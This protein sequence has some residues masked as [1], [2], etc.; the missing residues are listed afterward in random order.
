MSD[1]YSD[2]IARYPPIV[3]GPDQFP[4]VTGYHE[5]AAKHVSSGNREVRNRM[6]ELVGKWIHF[7]VHQGSLLHGKM[8]GKSFFLIDMEIKQIDGKKGSQE[9]Y[10]VDFQHPDTAHNAAIIAYQEDEKVNA[11]VCVPLRQWVS[12]ELFQQAFSDSFRSK[13][14]F[15]IDPGVP[16]DPRPVSRQELYEKEV[17]EYWEKIAKQEDAIPPSPPEPWEI[18]EDEKALVEWRKRQEATE[19]PK[20]ASSTPSTKRPIGASSSKSKGTRGRIR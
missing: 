12:E 18:K 2:I 20:P 4:F 5:E 19:D 7:G 14:V 8:D 6:E 16:E 10:R 3:P 9:K 15:R 13:H 1:N 17:V 11:E